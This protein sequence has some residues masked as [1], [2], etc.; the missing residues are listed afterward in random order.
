MGGAFD[1]H[2]INTASC[3]MLVIDS[4]D[5]LCYSCAMGTLET[6]T[7]ALR[8]LEDLLRITPPG[9]LDQHMLAERVHE[10]HQLLTGDDAPWIGTTVAKRLLG[11]GSENTVK[12]WARIGLLRSR[13]LPHGRIQ[14]HL[15][16]VLQ[17]RAEND[18]LRSVE[19]EELSPEEL[20][21]IR[22]ERPGTNPWERDTGAHAQ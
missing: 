19:G 10:V 12:A 13:Q 9:E 2:P 15:D 5:S 22:E 3:V 21:V 14:V 11:V 4:F 17:R 20:R 6:A 1:D 7:T 16:D 18:A 8:D